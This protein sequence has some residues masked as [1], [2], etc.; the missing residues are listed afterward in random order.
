MDEGE[1]AFKIVTGTPTRKRYLG[2]PRPRWENDTRTDLKGIG[3]NTK[4]WLI[5]LEVGSFEE[6]L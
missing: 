1:S 6:L 2:R 3:I 5:R 4:N